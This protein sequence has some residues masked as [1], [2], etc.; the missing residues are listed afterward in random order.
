MLP[1]DCSN[2]LQSLQRTESAAQRIFK[3]GRVGTLARL[4]YPQSYAHETYETQAGK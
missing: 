4:R 1:K 2:V 3:D